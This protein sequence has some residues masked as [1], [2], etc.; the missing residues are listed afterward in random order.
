MK[1]LIFILIFSLLVGVAMDTPKNSEPGTTVI[2]LT[3]DLDN[4]VYP[5]FV[6]FPQEE[7]KVLYASVMD[8]ENV[9]ENVEAMPLWAKILNAVLLLTTTFAGG[10]LVRYKSKFGAAVGLLSEVLQALQDNNLTTPEIE[11]IKKAYNNLVSS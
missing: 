6:S 2:E 1:N 7:P 5:D 3:Y 11:R 9:S 4:P 10:F 8:G